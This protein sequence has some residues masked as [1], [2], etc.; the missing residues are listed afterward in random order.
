MVGVWLEDSGAG[1][2]TGEVAADGSGISA[3][4]GDG[5]LATAAQLTRIAAMRTMV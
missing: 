4:T 3:L 5:A 1:E 2:L